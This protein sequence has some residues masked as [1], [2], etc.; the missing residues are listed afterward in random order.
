MAPGHA[1]GGN[2]A[3]AARWFA[4][5]PGWWE[6][7][8]V[9]AVD[10][11]V[12]YLGGDGIRLEGRRV[13]DLGCGDGIMA[14]GL[15]IKTGA[16]SV[17]GLDLQPVDLVYLAQQATTHG[18]EPTHPR[19]SFGV[20]GETDLGVPDASIDAVVTWSV[21]EHVPDL[22]GLLA[23]I[24]RILVPDG[25][26]FIQIWPLYF[27]EHGSHL[28]PWFDESFPH[29]RIDDATLRSQLRQRVD[30]AALG[31]AMLDLYDSCNRLTI[32]QLGDAL[33]TAGFFVSKVSTGATSVHVPPELQAKPL[34]L[35]MLDEVKVLAVRV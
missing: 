21:F 23:E 22:P 27:S 6:S 15:A 7:H 9:Q 3:S 2:E 25:L 33:V 29:L 24:R 13:L 5:Q 8:Y 31:D 1:F 26:L 19:L 35:L 10:A 18:V 20:S 30:S 34:S 11:I 16:T 14:L 32:D 17:L 28:W 12:D 4:E